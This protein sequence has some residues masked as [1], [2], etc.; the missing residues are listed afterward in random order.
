M[1]KQ[2]LVVLGFNRFSCILYLKTA[3]L[4]YNLHITEF[5]HLKCTIQGLL[6]N[7]QSCATITT[8]QFQNSSITLKRSLTP[9][10]LLLSQITMNQLSNLQICLFW[11]FHK[12]DLMYSSEIAWRRK[13]PFPYQHMAM[14]EADRRQHLALNRRQ[15]GEEVESSTYQN[16]ILR[17]C[18]NV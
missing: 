17:E 13:N 2:P 8:I 9:R 3:L 18:F 12:W 6:V 5:T 10:S 16:M 14:E 15:W 1:V 7:L 4:M 11:T